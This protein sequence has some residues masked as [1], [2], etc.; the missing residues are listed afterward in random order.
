MN[1][2]TIGT[3]FDRLYVALLTSF[4]YVH[5]V[6]TISSLSHIPVLVFRGSSVFEYA[7]L[8][9]MLIQHHGFGNTSTV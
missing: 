1:M 8:K 4:P 2:T 9:Y 3:L 6:C 7:G 5:F